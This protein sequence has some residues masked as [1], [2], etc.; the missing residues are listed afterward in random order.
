[1]DRLLSKLA[2]RIGQ[3]HASLMEVAGRFMATLAH[4]VTEHLVVD[5]YR[6]AHLDDD[7]GNSS[8]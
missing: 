8:R 6:T 3:G 5:S 2:S 7:H 4:I 1:M